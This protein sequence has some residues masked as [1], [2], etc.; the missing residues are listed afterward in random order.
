MHQNVPRRQCKWGKSKNKLRDK[1]INESL[2]DQAYQVSSV[3]LL[4][5]S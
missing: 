3:D 4:S 2:L 1:Q 5:G